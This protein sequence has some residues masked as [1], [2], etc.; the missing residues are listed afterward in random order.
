[1][2]SIER[3]DDYDYG[4]DVFRYPVDIL[5]LE[6]KTDHVLESLMSEIMQKKIDKLNSFSD[7]FENSRWLYGD[8]KKEVDQKSLVYDYTMNL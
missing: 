6:K 2:E 4:L 5:F 8:A 1:M 7:E 3:S